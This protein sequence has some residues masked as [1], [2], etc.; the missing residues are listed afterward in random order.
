MQS[1]IR[2]EANCSYTEYILGARRDGTQ[3]QF[4]FPELR[5]E[6]GK[7]K[8]SLSFTE[9]LPQNPKHNRNKLGYVLED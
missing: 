9:R 2:D 7:L 5:Q 1:L 3:L 8:V 4:Q 6:D